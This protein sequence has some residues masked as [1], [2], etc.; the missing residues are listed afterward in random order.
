[1]SRNKFIVR[2]LEKELESDSEWSPGFF[3][4]F[5]DLDHEHVQAVDEM[6]ASIKARRGGKPP[7]RL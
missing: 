5:Q 2:A 6:L 7:P 3:E 4:L 1:M